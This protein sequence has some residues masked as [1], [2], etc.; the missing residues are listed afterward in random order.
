MPNQY[1]CLVK[2]A[3]FFCLGSFGV[4]TKKESNDFSLNPF[5]RKEGLYYLLVQWFD[6]QQYSKEPFSLVTFFDTLLTSVAKLINFFKCDIKPTLFFW[7]IHD[8]WMRESN[9]RVHPYYT[10][11]SYGRVYFV[12]SNAAFIS[13]ICW[14]FQIKIKFMFISSRNMSGS[15]S[16]IETVSDSFSVSSFE[17]K[18]KSFSKNVSDLSLGKTPEKKQKLL[19]KKVWIIFKNNF[20]CKPFYFLLL[21]GQKRLWT[22][23]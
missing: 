11:T 6:I 22:V 10:S 8:Y 1:C 20:W 21:T 15:K 18:I 23:L 7:K 3:V 17:N 5:W 2:M 9:F 16:K 12:V 14:C 19:N 13:S 4:S